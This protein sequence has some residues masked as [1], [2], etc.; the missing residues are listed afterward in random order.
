MVMGLK[1]E[2]K[3]N[4]RKP[5]NPNN[6]LCV[7]IKNESIANSRKPKVAQDQSSRIATLRYKELK[8][9]HNIVLRTNNDLDFII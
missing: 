4:I 5:S 3:N 8:N 9:T 2:M 7:H 6:V 1:E